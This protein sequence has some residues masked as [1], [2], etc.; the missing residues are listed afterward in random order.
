MVIVV[1]G[2]KVN[3]LNAAWRDRYVWP[4]L[5]LLEP[6]YLRSAN[7]L[8]AVE[9]PAI[10]SQYPSPWSFFSRLGNLSHSRLFICYLCAVVV[11]SLYVHP[12]LA[13]HHCFFVR[14][15]SDFSPCDPEPWQPTH[16]R[17]HVVVARPSPR[18]PTHDRFVTFC[19]RR[20][21][22][23]V[24]VVQFRSPPHHRR[25]PLRGVV[26]PFVVFGAFNQFVC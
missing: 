16:P 6:L 2:H 4:T 19:H 21:T 5:A 24:R 1:V 10:G 3:Y 11:I 8:A 12:S 22:I 9:L 25:L 23:R 18:T 20:Y 13:A 17:V 26:G 7:G 15:Q 14:R